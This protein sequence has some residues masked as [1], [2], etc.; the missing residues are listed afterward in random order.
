MAE[1]LGVKASMIAEVEHVYREMGKRGSFIALKP[2]VP[3]GESFS[4]EDPSDREEDEGDDLD[5]GRR[6]GEGDLRGQHTEG[7]GE[8]ALE[9]LLLIRPKGADVAGDGEGDGDGHCRR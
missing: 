2:D 8:E 6:G 4:N 1:K 5:G 3:E 9:R 7:A